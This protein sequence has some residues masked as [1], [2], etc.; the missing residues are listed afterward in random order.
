V[1]V[2]AAVGGQGQA[3]AAQI[4]EEMAQQNLRA[5]AQLNAELREGFGRV[6]AQLQ[7]LARP[8]HIKNAMLEVIAEV[9]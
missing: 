2:G 9:R 4:V 6:V 3:F 5:S 1:G 7:Q 8:G